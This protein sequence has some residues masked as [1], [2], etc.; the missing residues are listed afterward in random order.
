MRPD[1]AR[2]LMADNLDTCAV[3][4][5]PSTSWRN[6]PGRIAEGVCDE[7]AVRETCNIAE[8]CCGQCNRPAGVGKREC[9]PYGPG[10]SLLCAGC[11]FGEDGST[12]DPVLRVEAERRFAALLDGAASETGAV[13]IGDIAGPRPHR[14]KGRN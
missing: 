11:M 9:R 8:P 14:A 13:E 12:P 4:Q 6:G 2:P 1:N 5:R 3:C 10:G 7:H